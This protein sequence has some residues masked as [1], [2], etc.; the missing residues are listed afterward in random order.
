[1]SLVVVWLPSAK[2]C[3]SVGRG[4]GGV[5]GNG[6]REVVGEEVE[7]PLGACQTTQ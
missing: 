3:V 6:A 2:Q 1:M 5:Q 4:G 7:R